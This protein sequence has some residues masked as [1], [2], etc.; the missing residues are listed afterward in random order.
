MRHMHGTMS[1]GTQTENI[2][3]RCSTTKYCDKA[4]RV[5]FRASLQN[6]PKESWHDN[7]HKKGAT[8]ITRELFL[9]YFCFRSLKRFFQKMSRCRRCIARGNDWMKKGV[10]RQHSSHLLN[11]FFNNKNGKINLFTLS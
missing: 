7:T 11:I 8:N 4:D 3:N 2:F 5:S 6:C 1:I 9:N 10:L